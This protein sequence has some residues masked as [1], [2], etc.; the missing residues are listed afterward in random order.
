[1]I[2]NG[3]N[4]EYPSGEKKS[5]PASMSEKSLGIESKVVPEFGFKSCS[6]LE[7]QSDNT[8]VDMKIGELLVE[9]KLMESDFHPQALTRSRIIVTWKQF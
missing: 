2:Q 8:E 6:L 4:P 3:A 5:A 7:R 1:M 9:A